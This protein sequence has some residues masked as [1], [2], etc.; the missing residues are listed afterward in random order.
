MMR[1]GSNVRRRRAGIGL[2]ACVAPLALG[3]W[4]AKAQ[5]ASNNTIV[6]QPVEVL[7][8]RGETAL[9]PVDGYAA[10]RSA[11]ATKTD[12]PLIET[13]QSVSVVTAR[14]VREKGAQS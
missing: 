10:R 13:P 14:E 12:T 6:L 4:N 2:V 5:E 9:G 1:L 11:T 3:A 8:K 7:G